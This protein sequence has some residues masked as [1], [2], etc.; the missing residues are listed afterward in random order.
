MKTTMNKL[1]LNL[2]AVR[3]RFF[4]IKKHTGNHDKTTELID[5]NNI[6][7]LKSEKITLTTLSLSKLNF[8]TIVSIIDLTCSL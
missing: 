5:N 2:C 4:N 3:I 8:T 7:K 1:S 6:L